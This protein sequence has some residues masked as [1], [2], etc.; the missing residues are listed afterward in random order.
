V[1]P[2]AL[3]EKSYNAHVHPSR[4]RNLAA[5]CL[6]CAEGLRKR[7][8]DL[9]LVLAAVIQAQAKCTEEPSPQSHMVYTRALQVGAV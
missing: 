4:E 2:I 8:P 7:V 6:R 9:Q 3:L 5:G 1:K